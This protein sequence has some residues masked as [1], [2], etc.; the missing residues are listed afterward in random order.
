MGVLLR[1][2]ISGEICLANELR[3]PDSVIYRLNVI[4]QYTNIHRPSGWCGHRMA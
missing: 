3:K 1:V 2:G 4:A